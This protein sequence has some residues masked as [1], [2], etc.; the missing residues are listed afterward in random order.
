MKTG[1]PEKLKESDKRELL[2]LVKERPTA[3][4]AELVEEFSNRT[5]IKAHQ[6][7]LLKALTAFGFECHPAKVRRSE[8]KQVRRYG[9]QDRHRDQILEQI[10]P[11]CLSDQEWELVSDIFESKGGQGLPPRYERRFLLDACCY[12]VRTGCSWRML[13]KTY[14]HGQGGG[15]A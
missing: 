1:R 12:V 6:A 11:S 7:T 2:E 9:Y 13:P 4:W 15:R 5:G 3:I 14:P 10:Y 8:K